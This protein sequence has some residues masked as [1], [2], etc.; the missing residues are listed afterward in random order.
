MLQIVG[1]EAMSTGS[2]W[3]NRVH[4]EQTEEA[5]YERGLNCVKLCC[6]EGGAVPRTGLVRKLVGWREDADVNM[7]GRRE[8]TRYLCT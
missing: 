3:Q 7:E 4:R 1:L 5:A 6:L 8:G 2:G